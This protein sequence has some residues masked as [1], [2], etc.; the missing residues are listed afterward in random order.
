[1]IAGALFQAAEETSKSGGLGAPDWAAIAALGAAV[2]AFL[3]PLLTRSS[4][5]ALRNRI[6]KDLDIYEKLQTHLSMPSQ[7]EA[8]EHLIRRELRALTRRNTSPA[9]Q[10][11]GPIVMALDLPLFAAYLLWPVFSDHRA[12]QSLMTVIITVLTLE[13][14]FFISWFFVWL[15]VRRLR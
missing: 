8:L 11:L 5:R 15:H 9:W 6:L 7:Q 14:L 4:E 10:L 1:M 13:L 3:G 2:A 12:P